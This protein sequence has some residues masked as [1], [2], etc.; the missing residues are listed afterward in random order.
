[1]FGSTIEWYDF[2]VYGT[3][4]ATVFGPLFF[5]KSDSTTGL[6]A[7]FATFAVGFL[8]RPV[9]A[10]IFGHIGDRFGRKRAL[11]ATLSIMGAAT[12]LIG[13]LPTYARIGTWAPI[14]L[15]LLRLL[16]GISVG[17]EWGGSVLMAGEHAP[18]GRRTWHASMAQ[19]GSPLAVLLSLGMFRFA[20]AIS[21]DQF[22]V[23][24]WR[25][26]FLF[27]IVLLFVGMLIR[28]RV[29]ESPEFI[30]VENRQAVVKQP[31]LEAFR[32]SYKPILMM[33][34]AFTIGTAGF[35]F[36]STFLISY[37][38]VTLSMPRALVLDSLMIVGVVQ[39]VG[40]LCTARIAE[41]IGDVKL[42]KWAAGLGMLAP[43]PMFMLVGTKSMLGIVLG[44]SIATLCGSG[45]YAVIAGY[46]SKVFGAN[47]RYSAISASYQ[48][49][50]AIFGGF[51]PMIGVMLAKAYP[52]QWIPLA[53]FYTILSGLSFFGVVLLA[54]N[55]YGLEMGSTTTDGTVEAYS[56]RVAASVERAS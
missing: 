31:V 50:G 26:P 53:F 20:T 8:A 15:V 41:L 3:A 38:T 13:L 45:F 14:L 6:L 37:A 17:G 7:A 46:A 32:T 28:L 22:M 56:G 36:T 1:L 40:Q 5:S 18:K 10:A 30:E 16:Q 51:T 34:C 33:M 42:L 23:W 49:G 35:Y 24:G 12:T 2:F 52:G 9:G 48:L 19:L 21:G 55:G 54:G 27:S 47:I 43:Y 29:G 4:A 44:V 39:F 25:V 11:I